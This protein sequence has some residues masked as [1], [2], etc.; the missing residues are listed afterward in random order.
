MPVMP[1][2]TTATSTRTS[3]TSASCEGSA[4]VFSQMGVVS[5]AGER[6]AQSVMLLLSAAIVFVDGGPSPGPG[7]A[8]ADTALFVAFLDM[9]GLTLLLVGVG[10]FISL[11]HGRDGLEG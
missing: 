5:M 2:P 8:G 4:A 11:G 7:R 1:P 10:A 9:G 3:P 6:G